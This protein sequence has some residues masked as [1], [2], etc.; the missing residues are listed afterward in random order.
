MAACGQGALR[1]ELLAGVG[2]KPVGAGR[3]MVAELVG[4]LHYFVDV[5]TDAAEE[6]NDL[7]G[8][9]DPGETQ[10]VL[11]DVSANDEGAAQ[12]ATKHRWAGSGRKWLSRQW[13][14]LGDSAWQII[15]VRSSAG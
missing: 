10:K 9:A 4:Q 11:N 13:P 8:G 12:R 3:R 7:N 15:R 1:A 6:T 2:S 5:T 14:R